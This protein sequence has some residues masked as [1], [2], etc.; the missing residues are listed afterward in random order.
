MSRPASRR[1]KREAIVLPSSR[2]GQAAHG[3]A[4]SGAQ[5]HAATAAH[6]GV[7]GNTGAHL[8]QEAL[9]QLPLGEGVRIIASHPCGLYALEKPEGILSHPNKRAEAPRSLL[10]APYS[11]DKEYFTVSDGAF[12]DNPLQLHLLHR[13][14]S[15]TSGLL[16]LADN[17]AVAACVRQAF[18]EDT[19]RK[20]YLALCAG[21]QPPRSGDRG[22]WTD[23]LQRERHSGGDVLHVRSGSGQSACTEYLCLKSDAHTR[24]LALLELHPL[25]GRT[26]QLRVH[27]AAHG[28][29]IVGDGKYGDFRFNRSVAQATGMKRLF[30]HAAR[31]SLAFTFEKQQ[32]RFTA[33]SP[34]PPQFDALLQSAQQLS[35]APPAAL[36]SATGAGR[37]P[38]A[39]GR[40][41]PS[42]TTGTH[43]KPRVQSQPTGTGSKAGKTSR[44]ARPSNAK[45]SKQKD[46]KRTRGK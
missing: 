5:P 33:E 1:P 16:L 22:R 11:L 35:K 25:S 38:A 6:Y 45:P 41:A 9:Q 42:A 8:S 19:V 17:A 4:A 37:Q 21:S 39:R 32:I 36:F 7:T 34:L 40:T 2:K 30:L 26:H 12:A 14:D 10:N 24:P 20:T 31:V 44:S 43:G 29:P 27:C 18:Q 15:A 28:L 13:L 23:R 46:G 3:V